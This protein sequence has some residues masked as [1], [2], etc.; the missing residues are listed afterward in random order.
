MTYPYKV[1][2]HM[3]FKDS[4]DMT[5]SDLMSIGPHSLI[6]DCSGDEKDYVFEV[7]EVTS[8]RFGLHITSV[9]G[10]DWEI[11][12]LDTFGRERYLSNAIDF[13]LIAEPG[14]VAM[15]IAG[16]FQAY[17]DANNLSLPLTYSQA[18]ACFEAMEH[19]PRE[20]PWYNLE[21][22]WNISHWDEKIKAAN[23]NK[24]K[25]TFQ[26]Y[27]NQVIDALGLSDEK[28][29]IPQLQLWSW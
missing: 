8:R 14:F 3:F 13:K 2:I 4:E 25:Y 23:N 17:L 29:V 7:A 16:M 20:M 28:A 26:G 6:Q 9:T 10:Q 11:F 24:E 5:K 19:I 15:A 18:T 21:W 12:L 1:P 22:I 27:R